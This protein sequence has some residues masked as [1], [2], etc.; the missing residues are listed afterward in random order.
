[1]EMNEFDRPEGAEGGEDETV[2][3]DIPINEDD[4]LSG[5]DDDQRLDDVKTSS[6]REENKDDSYRKWKRQ[7]D[8]LST[9][10]KFD[11]IKIE[12]VRRLFQTEYRI[13]P[14]DGRNSKEFISSLD[15]TKTKLTFNGAD[16]A[17]IDTGGTYKMSENKKA[18][19]SSRKFLN[20][21]EKALTEHREIAK[22][23]VEKETEGEAS[24]V[25]TEEIFEDAEEEFRQEV[26]NA[27]DDLVEYARELG[28]MGKITTQERREFVRV[29]APKV[30]PEVR[31]KALRE[32]KKVFETNIEL[33]TDPE[34]RQIIQEGM[35][36]AEQG[37]YK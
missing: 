4:F 3:D 31:I 5:L 19:A 30:P 35:D 20:L 6:F 28:E 8:E 1:M 12:Y 27:G 25:N 29:T 10:G 26:I 15:I 37:I 33:E 24:G 13:D 21:Y 36:V 23:V 16:V 34:R 9:Y 11:D 2:I 22:S 32:Q 14:T 7:L 18:T 17:Y